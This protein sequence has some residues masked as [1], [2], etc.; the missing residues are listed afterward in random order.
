[1]SLNNPG[2][3]KT[4]IAA[5]AIP[6]YSVVKLAA[7]DNEVGLATAVT[8]PLLGVSAE[9]AEVKAGQRVDVIFSG[10]TAV[11]AAESITKGAWLTVHTD[12]RVKPAG[13][14]DERIGRALQAAAA[15]D[16]L[17]IEIIKN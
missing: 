3:I 6:Q 2:L 12:G 7:G 8:D 14:T 15:G 13:S 10:I 16:V 1:M 17:S 5:T 4:F 9:P 11:R